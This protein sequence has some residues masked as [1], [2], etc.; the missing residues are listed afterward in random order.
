MEPELR[1]H[2]CKLGIDYEK[3]WILCGPEDGTDHVVLTTPT[4][5]AWH[6][7]I[8]TTAEGIR[9]GKFIEAAG[10]GGKDLAVK[11]LHDYKIVFVGCKEIFVYG[12]ILSQKKEAPIFAFDR[13]STKTV[14]GSPFLFRKTVYISYDSSD[15]TLVRDLASR[16]EWPMNVWLDEKSIFVGDSISAAIDTGLQSCDALILCLS[17]NSKNSSWVRREYAYAL[18]KGI[19]VLPVRLD[20][21]SPPPTLADIKYIDFPENEEACIK[22]IFRSVE[23]ST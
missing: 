11:L 5:Y 6:A 20:H 16:L 7:H 17:E 12:L 23:Q 15:K 13:C 10:Y 3:K 9:R 21:C 22:E 19:K 8:L 2:S 18:H 14:Q 1:K 4:L